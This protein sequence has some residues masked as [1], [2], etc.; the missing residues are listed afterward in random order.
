MAGPSGASHPGS[1]LSLTLWRVSGG[2]ASASASAS[3]EKSDAATGTGGGARSRTRGGGG[4]AA[5]VA[6]PELAAMVP[7][8]S[9]LHFVALEG[10]SLMVPA[11][12]AGLDRA[13]PGTVPALLPLVFPGLRAVAPPVQV[14]REAYYWM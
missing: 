10:G 6:G 2:A 3:G 14:K 1:S 5:G 9:E 13:P 8:L 4:A 11:P 7:R 12:R